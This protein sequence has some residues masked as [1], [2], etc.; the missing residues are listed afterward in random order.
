[1]LTPIVI[2]V[3]TIILENKFFP[4]VLDHIWGRADFIETSKIPLMII[5]LIV[6]ALGEEI[7]IRAF[8]Q[9]Q[10]T[11]LIGFVPSLIL[12]SAIFA[13]GHF[14]FDRPIIVVLDLLEVFVDSLFFGLVFKE[15][16]NAWCSWL[17]HFV[18]NVV[19]IFLML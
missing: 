13:L 17:S 9:K 6:F 12:T 8:Y 14:T 10:T 18:G 3:L 15:T 7:A 2:D 5:E 11:K 4:E 19:A 16:D 1:M